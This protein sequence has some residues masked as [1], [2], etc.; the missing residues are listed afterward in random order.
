MYIYIFIYCSV[1]LYTYYLILIYMTL[2][3]THNSLLALVDW[4]NVCNLERVRKP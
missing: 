1:Y 4:N 2:V 3:W